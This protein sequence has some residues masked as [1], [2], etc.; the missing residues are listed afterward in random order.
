MTFLVQVAPPS[1]DTPSN[2][3]LGTSGSVAIVTMLFGLVG[4]TAIASSASF[5]G[6]AL[7]LIF[8]GIGRTAA[9]AGTTSSNAKA[10]AASDE[11]MKLRSI[12]ARMASPSSIH[13]HEG[14]DSRLTSNRAEST[15]GRRPT[16]G[17]PRSSHGTPLANDPPVWTYGKRTTDSGDW[18]GDP[19]VAW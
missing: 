3:P 5:P 11:G 2:R 8:A 19:P 15:S 17:K 12:G 16:P 9:A 1:N 10:S 14:G 18:L 7:V 4:L 6:L 13:L